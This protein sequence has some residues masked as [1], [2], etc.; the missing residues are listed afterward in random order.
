ML[1]GGD[2][3]LLDDYLHRY[4]QSFYCNSLSYI[5]LFF[6]FVILGNKNL[7]MSSGPSLKMTTVPL[8]G[9]F[10][11]VIIQLVKMTSAATFIALMAVGKFYVLVFMVLS[12]RDEKANNNN[13]NTV[14]VEN[15][16]T[17]STTAPDETVDGIGRKWLAKGY[18]MHLGILT[19]SVTYHTGLAPLGGFWL[20]GGVSNPLIQDNWRRPRYLIFLCGNT[21][22][23]AASVAVIVLLLLQLLRDNK[24]LLSRVMNTMMVLGLLGLLVAYAAGSCRT[25]QSIAGPSPPAG[26][27]DIDDGAGPPGKYDIDDGAGGLLVNTISMMVLG[28]LVNTISMMVLDVFVLLMTHVT[29]TCRRLN[30]G[31]IHPH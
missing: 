17:S 26:K 14:V 29:G 28:L 25:L 4:K 6:L 13:N 11:S 19:A 10:V 24:R 27:Y 18:L 16:V 20:G 31:R 1:H 3:V 8:V 15:D 23:F 22:S 9:F 5:L 12:S 2:K 21:A 30:C 7:H